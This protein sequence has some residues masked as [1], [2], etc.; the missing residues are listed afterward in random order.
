MPSSMPV[1]N[2]GERLLLTAIT[3]CVLVTVLLLMRRGWLK[4]SRLQKDIAS[5]RALPSDFEASGIFT[6]RYVAS[7]AAGAWLTRI[8]AHT[9]GM[10]ARCQLEWG[11]HG[12]AVK[13]DNAMPFLVLRNEII[14]VRA[15]RAI[16]GRAF[17]RDG[18]VVV[19]W[20][21]GDVFIDSG[22]RFD[23][24]DQQVEFLNLMKKQGSVK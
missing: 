1:T 8:V 18:L 14:D 10:P 11:Q 23:K 2:W 5:P 22:F 20:K 4:R 19:T 3:L 21:L 24:A 17:E 6:A 16:A 7:T 15:D 12:L 9:L 13:R